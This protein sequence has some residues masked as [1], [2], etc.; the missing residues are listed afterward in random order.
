MTR[1]F[2]LPLSLLA[3]AL[4]AGCGTGLPPPP[5][6]PQPLA[7]PM[8]SATDL[9]KAEQRAYA[10]G[11]AAGRIYQKKLDSPVVPAALTPGAATAAQAPP[12]APVQPAPPAAEIYSPKGLAQPVVTP[13]D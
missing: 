5:Q 1:Q 9:H 10:A 12:M 13:A 11:Y 8:L 6:A 7:Q 3:L 4:L 2:T